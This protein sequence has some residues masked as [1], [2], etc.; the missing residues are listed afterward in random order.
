MRE[1]IKMVIALGVEGGN[2]DWLGSYRS[3]LSGMTIMFYFC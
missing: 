2:K 3:E 1:E